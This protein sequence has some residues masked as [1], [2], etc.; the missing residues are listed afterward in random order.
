MEMWSVRKWAQGIFVVA[1][2]VFGSPLFAQTANT[3][4][5]Y[6]YDALNR[7]TQ[8]TDPSGFNTTYQYDGLSDPTSTTSPDSGT[9]AQ[10]FDAAGNVLTATDAKG[11]T[12]SYTYDADNRRLTATY[13]DSTLNVTYA[14]DQSNA[15]TGCSV[16]YP[17]GR[18]TQVVENSVTT[19]L[20]Y[21]GQGF[22]IQKM[23]ALNGQTQVTNYT[24]S[25]AGRLL[26]ITHPSGNQINY[27]RDGNGNISGVSVTTG[28]GTTTLVSNVTYAPFGPVTSYTLGNGQTVTRTYD[29]NYRLTDLTSPG[30]ALHLARDAMG[31]ITAIGNAPGANPATE[32][33]AYDS[34]YRLNTV[35][36]ANGSI[37]ESATYNQAG[38]RLTKTGSGLATGIYAYNTGTHQLIATGNAARTVDANG[39]TTAISNAGTTYGFGFNDRNRMSV[40]QVNQSTVAT[41]LYNA[42]GLRV[43]K[44]TGGAT[45]T[46]NY[47]LDHHLL[48]E[49]GA[50]N[51]EYVYMDD[52][53]VANL[54]MQG[55]TTVAYVTADQTGTP[56][57]VEDGS[58]NVL[59]AWP[60][61]GNAWGELAPVTNGYTYNLRAPGQYYD[62]ESGLNSNINRDYDSGTGRYTEVD[63]LGQAGGLPLYVYAQNDPLA[64][65]DPLGLFPF[66]TPAPAG[67]PTS[68]AG[69]GVLPADPLAPPRSI[70]SPGSALRGL[71][72][73]CAAQPELC[74]AAGIVGGCLYPNSTA[75]SCAD[76]P[77]PPAGQCHKNNDDCEKEWEDAFR[78]CEN[79]NSQPNPPRGITGGYTNLY[80]CAKGLVSQRCGGN[81]VTVDGQDQ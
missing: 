40:V 15:V 55:T 22:V 20:C 19:T 61:E 35:T 46:Y 7:M 5:T 8:V 79:Y 67:G 68:P 52:I 13:A 39:N 43:A 45:E 24:R 2:F 3:T 38:D 60:Y 64:Y 32:S 62:A 72:A 29:A 78:M 74:V 73:L 81:R 30:F 69:P 27:S 44:T 18:L 9:K 48:G 36:E 41:Y 66:G 59:W 21:N 70:P 54:D 28:S 11:N 76:E 6:Q 23:Q 51:R 31:N 65:I 77:H 26:A 75:D 25:A 56:R 4:T 1:P 10:T 14:Y 47:D 63:P 34:L 80:Q 16:S 12:V 58:G 57:A 17:I 37:F 50:T 42:D 71:A 33:Y 49:Y 53:P